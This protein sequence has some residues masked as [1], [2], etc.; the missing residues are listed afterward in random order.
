[1]ANY[2]FLNVNPLGIKEKDCVCRAISKALNEEYYLI[3]RKLE[4]VAELFECEMLCECCYKHLLD[5]VYGL[6][7][8]EEFKGLTITDFINLHPTG[9]Y[10]VRVPQHLTHIDNGTILDIWDC[11]NEIVD[12]VWVVE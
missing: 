4:L 6:T 11:S 9:K 8:I 3:S 2:Q 10:I 5:Y 7:R 12:I 1:M